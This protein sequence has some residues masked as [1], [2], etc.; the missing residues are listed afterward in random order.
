MRASSDPRVPS[1]A[2]ES[3]PSILTVTGQP[4]VAVSGRGLAWAQSGHQHVREL[5]GELLGGQL[6]FW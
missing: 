1:T 4:L 5:A 6:T 2:A 3:T